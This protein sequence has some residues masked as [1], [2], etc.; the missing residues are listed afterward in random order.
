MGNRQLNLSLELAGLKSG[1]TVQFS[2]MRHWVSLKGRVPGELLN[3]AFQVRWHKNLDASDLIIPGIENLIP[4]RQADVAKVEKNMN[5]PRELVICFNKEEKVWPLRDV[6]F[7]KSASPVTF[8]NHEAKK[9]VKFFDN[10]DRF[11]ASSSG[12][13]DQGFFV[14]LHRPTG[15]HQTITLKDIKLVYRE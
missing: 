6:E 13:A 7:L 3:N 10:K 14:I 1:E 2:I 8:R 9:T 11:L 5:G 12:S 15:A 4:I